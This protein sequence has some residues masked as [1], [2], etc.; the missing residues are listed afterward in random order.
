MSP[1]ACRTLLPQPRAATTLVGMDGG[2]GERAGVKRTRR[3]KPYA[4]T[5]LLLLL[6]SSSPLPL[7]V[8][9]NLCKFPPCPGFSRPTGRVVLPTE[10]ASERAT[11]GEQEQW[12][13]CLETARS[14]TTRTTT[15]FTSSTTMATS[16]TE[17]EAEA[18]AVSSRTTGSR[19]KTK[20]HPQDFNQC[21]S[22]PKGR[23]LKRPSNNSFEGSR[24]LFRGRR[25]RRRCRYR[26][27]SR[28]QL[29]VR[30]LELHPLRHHPC[31]QNS[32]IIFYC[33]RVSC[34]CACVWM[35]VRSVDMPQSLW[36]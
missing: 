2:R 9:T 7:S 13:A 19:R 6:P 22:R 12:G 18:E 34:V 4:V 27:A 17:T 31:T 25:R 36:I 3:E 11:D 24:T 29:S 1:A 33:V 15:T 10:R 8:K 5:K 20:G 14:W 32:M 35:F 16:E 23:L 26:F 21:G 28:P 30:F